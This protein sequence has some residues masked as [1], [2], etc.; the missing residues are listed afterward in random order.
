M[1]NI[2][3]NGVTPKSAMHF[4]VLFYFQIFYYFQ[5]WIFVL[6]ELLAYLINIDIVDISIL[7]FQCLIQLCRILR[8]CT[9][10]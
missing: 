10:S 2:Q 1:L 8:E 3:R 6:N 4:F 9:A 7:S 5:Y